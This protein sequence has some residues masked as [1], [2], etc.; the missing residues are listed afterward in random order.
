VPIQATTIVQTP[1]VDLRAENPRIGV[2]GPGMIEELDETWMPTYRDERGQT[3]DFRAF[4]VEGLH[5]V[6]MEPGA[7]RGNHAHDRDE[8][9][10]IL[11]GSEVCEVFATDEVSGMTKRIVVAGDL[12][13]YRIKA[14]IKHL[15]TNMGSEPFYLICFYEASSKAPNQSGSA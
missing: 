6:T 4:R 9:L 3:G 12:R 1:C 7:V 13:A 5:V 8:I 15:V 14:G 10:C 2:R 11:G